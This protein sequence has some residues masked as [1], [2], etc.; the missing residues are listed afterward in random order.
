M[1]ADRIRTGQAVISDISGGRTE[2]IRSA[3]DL[4]P[5]TS[6]IADELNRQ[7]L[8]GYQAPTPNDGRW[9]EIRVE[10]KGRWGSTVRTRKGYR[11][12]ILP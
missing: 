4:G 6:G 9:H 7:Y 11:A 1:A 5:A 8:I 12:S 3:S 2:I 10:V